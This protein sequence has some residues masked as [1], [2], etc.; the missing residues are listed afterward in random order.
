MF[1]CLLKAK[2]VSVQYPSVVVILVKFFITDMVAF[3]VA[4]KIH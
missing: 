1:I 3:F 4:V 2:A